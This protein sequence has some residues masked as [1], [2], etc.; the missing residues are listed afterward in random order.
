VNTTAIRGFT[1]ELKKSEERKP[2]NREPDRPAPIAL[3]GPPP[4]RRR[5]HPQPRRRRELSRDR[6]GARPRP[7]GY[8]DR[9]ADP[10][11]GEQ[12]ATA[13]A[14]IA[15]LDRPCGGAEEVS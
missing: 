4:D 15:R 11:G 6:G 2:T 14:V 10:P 1:T 13:G 5:D 3:A 9:A 8:H 12:V 7:A